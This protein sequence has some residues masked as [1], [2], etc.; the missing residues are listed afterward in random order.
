MSVFEILAL[1][2]NGLM[3]PFVLYFFKK[4]ERLHEQTQA[5][6]GLQD[7]QLAVLDLR[8]TLLENAVKAG[9]ATP[10]TNINL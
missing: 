10:T 5:K 9:N 7:T 4:N 6:Q 2:A 3:F 1:S 8:V